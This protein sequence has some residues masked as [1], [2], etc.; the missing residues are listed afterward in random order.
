MASAER[1]ARAVAGDAHDLAGVARFLLRFEALASSRIEGIAPSVKQVAVAE[2]GE[3]E[4]MPNVKEMAQLVA[5]N[6]LV[7]EQAR[8]ELATAD[9]I[10]VEQLVRLQAALLAEEPKKHGMRNVQ[11]WIGTS[12]SPLDAAFVPPAAD[13]VPSLMEDLVGYLA[14]A[15]HAP[16][17][18]AALAHAQF[19][20]IHPF[21]DGNGRVGRSLIHT[22]LTRRGLTPGAVLPVSLV[23]S[24]LRDEYIRGLT[25]YRHDGE[26]GSPEYH[27][28]RAEW[29]R[30]FAGA[31][32]EAARQ[33]SELGVSLARLREEWD[34]QYSEF[35][36]QAGHTRSLRADSATSLILRDLPSTPVLTSTT[37]KRIHD[38][39]SQAASNAL[40]ELC[41][42]G[43]LRRSRSQRITL[44]QCDDV[45][46]LV[47]LAERRLASTQFDTRVSRPTKPVPALPDAS[48]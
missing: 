9:G 6:I 23:L 7:V 31:V 22:V 39:S 44:Y 15:S 17:V 24:T 12:D 18:Q 28:A 10:T 14:T 27:A 26:V 1:A 47:T 43:I 4:P 16:I 2:L 41:S 35:R 42:A 21:I 37:V 3:Q 38:V 29:I 46:N 40:E 19:E 34:Q 45:L 5:N 11:N 30:V 36:I 25:A 33:A 48:A 32:E 20:T 8:T 13:A